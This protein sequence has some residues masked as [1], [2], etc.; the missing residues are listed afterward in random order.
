M[1]YLF[2]ILI[3]YFIGAINPS[4]IIARLKGFDIR[5]KGSRNAGASNAL[6]NFG[7][8]IGVLC[9]VFDILKATGAIILAEKLFSGF[10]N[11]FAVTAV[12]CIVGH[13][14]PF[15]MGFRG[16][17]GLAC[18]GGAILAFDIRVFA[19]ML[20]AEIAIVLL[21]D[22]ICFVPMTASVAFPIVF[23]VMESNVTGAIILC[24]ATAMILL[25]HVE[26]IKRIKSGREMHFSYL[27]NKKSET[28]RITAAEDESRS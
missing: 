14:F 5:E 6:I 26:N 20:A 11:A 18:L 16:G 24:I 22:Y 21:S 28:E 10:E 19:V 4:F 3:G 12:A 25:K 8:V 27:W 15:Y 17:K 7:K 2:C 9:A 13:I 23:A 1:E